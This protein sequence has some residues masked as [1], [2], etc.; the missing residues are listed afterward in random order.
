MPFLVVQ[1]KG[2]SEYLHRYLE[3]FGV[4]NCRFA[5]PGYASAC[6]VLRN[7]FGR[8]EIKFLLLSILQS[9]CPTRGLANKLTESFDVRNNIVMNFSC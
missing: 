6:A 5:S 1:D 7:H 4:G 9:N 3:Y 8:R 2:K